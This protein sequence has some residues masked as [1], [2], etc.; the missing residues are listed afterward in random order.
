MADTEHPRRRNRSA[1]TLFGLFG[2]LLLVPLVIVLLGGI[3]DS[4][5]NPA[6]AQARPAS[7]P[8]PTQ[9]SGELVVQDLSILPLQP[10]FKFAQFA[11]QGAI[12]RD[13]VVRAVDGRSL[14]VS[15]APRD[16]DR[17]VVVAPRT[18]QRPRT[19]DR[20][21][22]AGVVRAT[23]DAHPESVVVGAYVDAFQL[24]VRSD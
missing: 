22:L 13:L 10:G 15:G 3:G 20:I 18:G 1:L 9:V 7:G 8:P 19:G 16:R 17:L 12:G 6:T 4:A 11:G 14:L 23:D 24:R 2:L 5:D 21:D